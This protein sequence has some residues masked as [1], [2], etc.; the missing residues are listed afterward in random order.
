MGA[1]LCKLSVIVWYAR[2]EGGQ[3]GRPD[4]T[5]IN[6]IRMNKAKSGISKFSSRI[7]LMMFLHKGINT[8]VVTFTIGC[9]KLMKY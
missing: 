4:Y 7:A 6:P 9:A 5:R 8:F 3:D 2:E 1:V